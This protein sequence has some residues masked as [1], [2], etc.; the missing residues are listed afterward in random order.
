MFTP[1]KNT[2]VYEQVINQIKDMIQDGTLKKGDKLPSERDLVDKLEVSRTS[3]REALRVLEIVGIVECKQGEGNFVRTDFNDTLLEP[4][5]IMFMLNDCTLQEIFELRKVIEIE[6]AALA[7]KKI[8][9]S[10]LDDMRS[11]LDT[12]KTSDDE[13]EKVKL[14]TQFHYS[15]AKASQNFLIVSIINAVSTLMDSFIKDARKNIISNLHKEIIDKQH[16]K[17]WKALNNH[18]PSGAADA[19]RTHLELINENLN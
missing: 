13:D 4:L 16:D 3:I 5:S 1:I 19:M 17:I 18:N 12:I 2:K 8:T 15:I 7:A 9:E 10:Q 11:I 6:T 14:D